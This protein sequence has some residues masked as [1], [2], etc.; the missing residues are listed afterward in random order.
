MQ[1]EY[2]SESYREL[3]DL[4]NIDL[5]LTEEQQSAFREGL[6]FSLS[7]K[8]LDAIVER[9][10][11]DDGVENY[12]ERNSHHLLPLSASLFVM[13]EKLWEMMKRKV[14]DPEKMLAMSTIPLC[15]WD[16]K[17]ESTSNPKGIRRWPIRQN[18][19]NLSLGDE[20]KLAVAG[21][22][23]D[24]S[25][26]IEQSHLTMRKWGIPDSRRLIPNYTFEMLRIE[27][28]LDRAAISIHPSPREDFDYDFSDHARVFFEH[29]FSIHVEGKDVV[30]Q[31]GKK[32]PTQMTGNC[33]LLV[34]SRIGD[35]GKQNALLVD[36]WLKLFQKRMMR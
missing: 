28:V 36:I 26:F 3:V 7:E 19:L 24:F 11:A 20:S 8:Q 9:L 2:P 10:V 14:W 13:N 35:D 27:V 33:W 5:E 12:L 23:G 1:K 22:G 17:H 21:E 4:Y 32:K 34:G 25:G 15:A 29:G 6:T 30:L 31:I 18:A 16:Q